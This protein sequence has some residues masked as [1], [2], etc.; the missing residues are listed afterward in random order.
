M[1]AREVGAVDE[2]HTREPVVLVPGAFGFIGSFLCSAVEGLIMQ[3]RPAGRQAR[4]GASGR[5]TIDALRAN[6]AWTRAL[7]G[8]GAVVY[9][10][11]P[12]Q[13]DAASIRWHS[14]CAAK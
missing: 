3:V 13:A 10:A 8:V 4:K 11:R 12:A 14:L 2:A 9:T 1:V 6:M 7:K 5:Q